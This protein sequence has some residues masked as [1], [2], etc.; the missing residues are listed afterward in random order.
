LVAALEALRREP[1]RGGRLGL[2][3]FSRKRLEDV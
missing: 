1:R 3:E 2:Q